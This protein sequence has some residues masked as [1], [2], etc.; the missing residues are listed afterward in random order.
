MPVLID[1]PSN[2][3]FP[4]VPNGVMEALGQSVSFEFWS[5]VSDTHS[6]IRLVTAWHT[7][8]EEVQQLLTLLGDL[9]AARN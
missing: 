4:I 6:C 2:Q 8:K 7:T 5:S 3:I 1:S 9:L